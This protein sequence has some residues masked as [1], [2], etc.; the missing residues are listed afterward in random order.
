M[1]A[2]IHLRRLY[3]D[4]CRGYSVAE[5]GNQVRYVK[6]FSVFDYTEVDEV[7]ERAFEDVVRRGMRTEEQVKKWLADQ[8]LWGVKEDREL[9]IQEDY[10]ESLRKTRSKAHLISQVKQMDVQINEA[11]LK[12]AELANKHARLMDKTA[13]QAADQKVQ[14]EYMRLGFFTDAGLTTPLLTREAIDELSDGETE[15]LLFAYIDV[16]NRF[17][18]DTLRKIAVA[19]FFANYFYLCGDDPTRFFGKPV[20]HLTLNQVNLLSWGSNFKSLMTQNE[21]PKEM[22]GNPDKI[23]EFIARSR[24]MKSL[25]N[26]AGEGDRVALIGATKEDFKAL[27]VEDSTNLVRDDAK[28][29]VKSG[30]EAAKTREVTYTVPAGR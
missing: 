30:L 10:L 12:V 14:Y 18:S 6:H 3:S 22:Q 7:R 1:E 21:I 23:E 25:V 9:A 24:N 15:S 19:P 29:G 5:L 20:S 2:S 16:I 11:E 8:G 26:K 17:S 4:I 13:E 28:R 27:G